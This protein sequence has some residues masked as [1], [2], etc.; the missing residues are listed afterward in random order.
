M[1][2]GPVGHLE[3]AEA[4]AFDGALEA[5]ADG[6]AD[7]VNPLTFREHGEI[8]M[9]GWQFSAV[10]ETELLDET[11]GLGPGFLEAAEV[12]FVDPMFLLVVETDLNGGVTIALRGFNLEDG[13]AGNINDGDGNHAARLLIEQT[14]H[15]ELFA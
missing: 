14:G 1:H 15:A 8:G 3:A 12:G 13:V 4:V 6:G 9:S 5:F 2:H 10:G 7:D 11:L